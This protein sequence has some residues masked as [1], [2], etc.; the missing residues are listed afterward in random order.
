MMSRRI[1]TTIAALL[2]A[3]LA[4]GCSRSIVAPVT[5]L[6]PA[7]ATQFSSPL[8]VAVTAGSSGND[9][10]G[11]QV[12]YWLTSPVGELTVTN[13]ASPSSVVT[14]SMTVLAPPCRG[15]TARLEVTSGA[16]VIT[17]D[18]GSVTG[19]PIKLQL[20]VAPGRSAV[21]GLRVSSPACRLL[22]DVRQLYVALSDLTVS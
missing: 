13:R 19:V 7:T 21:V 15:L 3:V 5:D 6:V 11:G 17:R 20:K 10:V 14:L 22:P 12:H 8:S 1:P 9:G 2:C 18:V 16:G 4:A